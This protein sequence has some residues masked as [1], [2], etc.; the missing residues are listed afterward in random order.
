MTIHLYREHSRAHIEI[1]GRHISVYLYDK[2]SLNERHAAVDWSA[3]G[4]VNA[5]I[6]REFADD[7]TIASIIAARFEAGA[8]ADEALA[9]MQFVDV[10]AERRKA[11]EEAQS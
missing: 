9:N 6:S 8:T 3:I 5:E 7:L 10:N 1:N 4:S 2:S 11:I